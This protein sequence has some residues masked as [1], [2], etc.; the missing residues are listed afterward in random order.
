MLTS[1]HSKRDLG[2]EAQV[3]GS[4]ASGRGPRLTDVKIFFGG[5]HSTGV[6]DKETSGSAR[7]NRSPRKALTP[8]LDSMHS[9]NKGSCPSECGSGASQ[10]RS[11]APETVRCGA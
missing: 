9:Q 7:N 3:S 11:V 2:G 4:W 8:G 10:L 5:W 1:A 6:A